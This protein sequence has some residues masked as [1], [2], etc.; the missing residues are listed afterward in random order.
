MR[1]L[2]V[3]Y[4]FALD[5]TLGAGN[6]LPVAALQEPKE[7]WAALAAQAVRDREDGALAFLDL[8]SRD[9]LVEAVLQWHAQA[10]GADDV[11][12]VGIGGSALSARLFDALRHDPNSGPRLH[13]VDTVDPHVVGALMS[14]VDPERALLMIVS[15]SGGTLETAEVGK[16]LGAWMAAALGDRYPSRALAIAGE[17]DNPLRRM[18]V[19][20]GMPCLDIPEGVG[21]RFSALTAVGLAPAAAVGVD[22]L[23]LLAGARDAVERV[24]LPSIDDN[25]ALALAVL[26]FEAARAGRPVTVLLPYGETLRPLG[27]WWA[28]LVGESLGKASPAG[29]VGVTPVAATG[30]ADQHSL[31]QLLLEG[32]DDKLTV[33]VS[34]APRVSP[35]ARDGLSALARVLSA[36]C[37]ATRFTLANAGRPYVSIELADAYAESIGAFVLTYEMAVAYWGRLLEVNPFDQPAVQLGKDAALDR[38]R[39]ETD[40]SRLGERL[41]RMNAY[42]DLPRLRSS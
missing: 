13:V 20:A 27:P 37:E 29:P 35:D 34:Q 28:Q 41:E 38:L 39:G 18:A 9:D 14:D 2:T 22:P 3:D 19:E 17:A 25:P 42:R 16:V 33:F 10:P 1:H 21:G 26:H 24:L 31:L 23:R 36:E 15:K 30:P 12:V 7:R 5:A 11:I 40:P 32:P 4:T 6:G 8:A